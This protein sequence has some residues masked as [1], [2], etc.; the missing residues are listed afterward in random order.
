MPISNFEMKMCKPK[1][2]YVVPT[3]KMAW[4]LQDGTK[5]NP[6]AWV[7]SEVNMH[8]PR[9]RLLMQIAT[10]L[11]HMFK[12]WTQFKIISMVQTCEEFITLVPILYSMIVPWKWQ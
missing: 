3:Q 1:A 10:K 5:M 9:K 8:K 7:Q 2:C 4:E 11:I 12:S 6:Q